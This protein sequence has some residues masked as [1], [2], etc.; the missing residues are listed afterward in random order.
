MA[1]WTSDRLIA[2]RQRAAAL[3]EILPETDPTELATEHERRAILDAEQDEAR[4]T[5][6]AFATGLYQGQQAGY[7]PDGA[8]EFDQYTEIDSDPD[9]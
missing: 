8:A 4:Q 3:R 7:K 2:L 9:L 6:T 1:V 5:G